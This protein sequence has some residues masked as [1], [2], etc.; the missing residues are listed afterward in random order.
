MPTPVGNSSHEDPGSDPEDRGHRDSLGVIPTRGA[1]HAANVRPPAP[2]HRLDVT[3]ETMIAVIKVV[4][5]VLGDAVGRLDPI[6]DAPDS[7]DSDAGEPAFSL[8]SIDPVYVGHG[9]TFARYIDFVYSPGDCIKHALKR[10]KNEQRGVSV[11]YKDV[12]NRQY[13]AYERFLVEV[14]ELEQDLAECTKDRKHVIRHSLDRGHSLARSDNNGTLKKV[15]YLWIDRLDLVPKDTTPPSRVDKTALGFINPT[16]AKLLCPCKFNIDAPGIREGLEANRLKKKAFPLVFFA[17]FK[18]DTASLET[19]CGLLRSVLLLWTYRHIFTGP[20]SAQSAKS[21]STR[22][23]NSELSGFTMATYE[24]IAYAAVLLRSVLSATGR[25]SIRDGEF[26]Y[27]ECYDDIVKVLHKECDPGEDGTPSPAGK[28]LMEFWN[29]S[30]FGTSGA[31]GEDDSD[32]DMGAML[33]ATRAANAAAER[34]AAERAAAE[35][36]SRSTVPEATT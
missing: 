32:D 11:T 30:V 9:K 26:D 8:L 19:L 34:A 13:A 23:S 14:P 3:G 36:A 24:S 27:A 20:S 16:T 15:V 33:D 35:E 1:A 31:P 25:W 28:A 12:H 22:K 5:G 29:K 7:D 10:I 17:D 4:A 18:Y 2:P 6:D 21:L